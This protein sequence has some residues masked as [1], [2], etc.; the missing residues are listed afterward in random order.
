MNEHRPVPG[1]VG[2]LQELIG[3]FILRRLARYRDMKILEGELAHE[4]AVV[5]PH[6]LFVGEIRFFGLNDTVYVRGA[7]YD[8]VITRGHVVAVHGEELPG[9][10]SIVRIHPRGLPWAV[11]D[12]D[13][14]GS[15][16]RAIVQDET[17]AVYRVPVRV[18]RAT[19]DLIRIRET[20]VSFQIISSP[21]F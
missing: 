15:E 3:L 21:I 19:I 11:I 2:D 14:N 16:R 9:K 6:G 13:F 7:R 5:L 17:R 8:G 1:I 18:S 10:L 20:E 4:L 12:A